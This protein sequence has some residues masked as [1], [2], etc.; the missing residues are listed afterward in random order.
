M[1]TKLILICL[2]LLPVWN[3]Q[4][5]DDFLSY[6]ANIEIQVINPEETQEQIIHFL[7]EKG[8]YFISRQNFYLQVKQS[9]ELLMDFMNFLKQKGLIVN[10]EIGNTN[11]RENYEQYQVT[12]KTQS[13]TLDSILKLFD[14]AGLYEA[15]DI[16]KKIQQIIKEIEYAKGQIRY[17]EER[18]KYAYINISFKSYTSLVKTSID[19]PFD[20]INHLKLENLFREGEAQ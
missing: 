1:K 15:L 3:L 8:G 16:E 5:K 11:F 2:I 18:V 10:Q 4:A 14:Q 20:W 9:P 6:Y 13:E 19:S 12:L 7:K 17:I